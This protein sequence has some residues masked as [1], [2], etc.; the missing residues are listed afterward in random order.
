MRVIA[1][2]VKDLDRAKGRLGGALSSMERAAITLA[3]LEDVLAA[4]TQM[5]GWQTWVISP[6]P[7]VLQQ[8]ARMRARPLEEED[9]GLV[10]A[11]HQVEEE[12]GRAEALAVVLGDLPF[13]TPEALLGALQTLGTVVAAPSDSDQGTNLLLRRPPDAIPPLFGTQSFRK[14]REA[15]E[16]HDIPFATVAVPELGFD[17][18]RVEDIDALLAS[19]RPSR[20]KSICHELGIAERLSARKRA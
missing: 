17:L 1:V 13:L 5:P 19:P 12:A 8:A 4:C 7:A 16:L 9:P 6:D 18:D 14:H 2:P 20:A 3:M 10:A 15:A 11:I